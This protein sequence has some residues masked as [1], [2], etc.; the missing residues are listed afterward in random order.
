MDA[1]QLPARP[2]LEQYKKQAKELVKV[3]LALQSRK[4]SHSEVPHSEVVP[5][6]VA[7]SETIQRVK[8]HHPRFSDLLIDELARTKFSLA[9]AQFVI[10]REHGFESWPKF[11][12]HVEALESANSAA[13]VCEPV[14]AFI[15]AACVPRDALHSSGTLER[16][17]AILAAYPA[18]ANADIH[19]AAILC[20]AAAVQRFLALDARNATAKG[21]PYGWD[22][23]THLC[24]S[25]YL[26]LDRSRSDGFVAAAKALLDAGASANT[27]WMETNHEPHPEWESAI[28]G[29]AG[30]AQHAELTR[31]LLERGAD[32]NDGETPYHVVETYDNTVMKILVESGKLNDESMT[33][34]LLRKADWHDFE[35]IKWLLQ[36]GADPN[37]VTQWGRTAFHHAVLR[38]NSLDII[39]VLLEH[40]A[41]PTLAAE[42]PDTRQPAGPAMLGLAM[43]ARR[44]R[45]DVLDMIERRG[46]AIELHGVERLIAACA[47]NDSVKVRSIA[48]QEPESV[49]VLVAQGGKLLAEFAG[50][51]NTDGVRQLLDLGVG[52]NALTEEGDPY[53]DVAK[54]S[55]AMHSA[56]W[57]AR[58]ATVKLLIERGA[59]VNALD[60]KGRT[61]LAL[62][63]RAC[64]DSYWKER[65]TPESAEALLRA[66]ASVRGV[67]YPSG[68]AE[69]DELLRAHG[70]GLLE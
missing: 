54:D 58:P 27:G 44:G 52:V 62:A 25:R 42:R 24:F 35:G 66:G 48:A 46:T 21:G 63:V 70:A 45:G 43:A 23:L 53:F 3:F 49:R 40:G 14:A 51:G 17:E 22:A 33:T 26:R 67:E 56:A 5:S 50:V 59:Q 69:V 39:E 37:R 68:Y 8:T 4:S 19:A 10:A 12:K 64:V 36:H 60:G 2:S 61:A 41:D 32:P 11:A 15:V 28:Y 38:D 20:D 1:K 34:L 16:A 30:I 18:V 9:D 65:R 6:E 13:S 57:R 31:L 47:R 7:R 29:A 55:T